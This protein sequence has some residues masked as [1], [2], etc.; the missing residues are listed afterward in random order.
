MLRTQG[1]QSDSVEQ[2]V[3]V[4]QEQ[5]PALELRLAQEAE[6]ADGAHHHFH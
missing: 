3:Q 4:F 6:S 1:L 2:I 5:L